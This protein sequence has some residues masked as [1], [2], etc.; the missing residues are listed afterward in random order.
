M[1]VALILSIF[2]FSLLSLFFTP[3]AIIDCIAIDEVNLSSCVYTGM[4]AKVF[5]KS[6]IKNFDSLRI[7]TVGIIQFFGHTNHK[8]LNFLFG[9]ICFSGIPVN[10]GFSQCPMRMR[11]SEAGRSLRYPFVLIH[12][13]L[14]EF[15]AFDCKTN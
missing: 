15:E 9:G 6:L 3:D 2:P 13:Q 10:H 11:L 14:Q 4:S 1:I 7:L 12:S 5:C 8:C